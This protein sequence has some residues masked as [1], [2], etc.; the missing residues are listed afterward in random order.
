[1]SQ[2]STLSAVRKFMLWAFGPPCNDPYVQTNLDFEFDN[3]LQFLE[4][5]NQVSSCKITIHHFLIKV[6]AECIA[7]HPHLN[8]KIFGEEIYQLPTINIATPINLVDESW[9]PRFNELGVTFIRDADSK[10]LESIAQEV[11]E[12]AQNYKKGG[13]VLFIEEMAKFV[14]R[15][16]PN[17]SLRFFFKGVSIFGRNRLLYDMIHQLMGVST[18]FTNVGSVVK[19]QPGVHYKSVSF[20]LP[21]KMVYFS[22]CFGAGPI[23]KKPIVTEN[24]QVA[25]RQ[26]LP[27][28]IVFDHRIIDAFLMN[29]FINDFGERLYCPEQYYPLPPRNGKNTSQE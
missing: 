18:V 12:T 7:R 16:L 27:F 4:K 20:S 19:L 23:E 25:I 17:F 11:A 1:M 24:D 3:A 5:Y 14:Y 29:R 9:S 6:L 2:K 21:D 8:V 22:C 15:Y 10:S 26:M 13:R 28:L